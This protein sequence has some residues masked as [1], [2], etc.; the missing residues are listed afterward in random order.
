MAMLKLVIAA[1][2]LLLI[3]ESFAQTTDVSNGKNGTSLIRGVKPT[4]ELRNAIIFMLSFGVFSMLVAFA[5]Q[6]V[7]KY[8]YND[9]SNVDTTFDAGG[10]VSIGLTATT[11]VSQMTWTATL[12]QS[13]TVATKYGISGPL[14]YGAAATIQ[15]FVFAILSIQFKTKAPGAKTFL[16]V[17]RVRFG[18]ATHILFCVFAG[19]TNILVMLMLLLAGTAVLHSLILDLSM[20]LACILL[21][22]LIGSYTLIGG[23]GATFYVSY[24]NTSIV[25]CL[26]IVLLVEVFHKSS[27]ND[28][29]PLGNANAMYTYLH[30]AVGPVG[31]YERSYLTIMSSGGLMF[32][33]VTMVLS[34]SVI[35]GDQSYWQSSI[36]A[37]PIHGVW[38]FIAGGLTWFSIP[39]VMAMTFGL[40]YLALGEWQGAPLL[41]DDDVNKGL[42]PPL[43][44]QV[45]LGRLGEYVIFMLIIMAI[46]ST[47]SAEVIAVASLIV[48][49][50][51]QPYLNPFR[52]NLKGD[53]CVLCGERLRSFEHA[54]TNE[55]EE[56]CSCKPAIQCPECID[57]RTNQRIKHTNGITVK[58][59][60]TCSV[61]GLYQQYQEDLVGYKSWCILWVTMF[62][63]PLVLCSDWVGLNL[64]WVFNFT[65]V[66]ISSVGIPICLSILWS[67]TNAKGMISGVIF[68]C[69]CGMSLWLGTASRY[70]GGLSRFL[71]NTGREIPMLVGNCGSVITGGITCMV[72]SFC[73][74]DRK[75]FNASDVWEKMRNIEN[76]LHPWI[77]T[78]ARDFG[79]TCNDKSEYIRP[80]HEAIKKIYRKPFILALIAGISLLFIFIVLWP[81][82]MVPL[83]VM[84]R[85]QFNVWAT[86]SQAYA[87]I[88]A[89]FIIL[90]P[91]LQEIYLIFGKA[92]KNYIRKNTDD[93]MADS[94]TFESSLLERVST[95]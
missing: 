87:F 41:S 71:E 6:L 33:V 75:H 18:K 81:A 22:F 38:G 88:V 17:I 42:V 9:V 82:V 20:S 23:L 83:K 95:M 61:H 49:D 53:S 12:L 24:F 30:N 31:N 94:E 19:I 57:D 77:I 91:L 85:D 37:K 64:A 1:V 60:Y 15:T 4:I 70:E 89:A 16:Q 43:I 35:I 65:G 48:Y 67:M 50:V 54:E 72:V 34:F 14:W 68:G 28:S 51:Y 2:L 62:T 40:A 26:M 84:T 45:L 8:V 32:G 39:F 25:F 66:L 69:V 55:K 63:I 90:V 21:A 27:D 79:V 80:T 36:A 3:H 52:D 59:P 47:G 46:M 11:I 92:R 56:F 29:N 78:Y 5:F 76:P 10:K 73:T 74:T 86:F 93:N 13:T 44:A 7:R 58:R